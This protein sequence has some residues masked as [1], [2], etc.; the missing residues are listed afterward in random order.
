[1]GE[2]GGGAPCEVEKSE[3]V[4]PRANKEQEQEIDFPFSLDIVPYFFKKNK[5]VLLL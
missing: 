4:L 3:A 5:H 1:M 2:V